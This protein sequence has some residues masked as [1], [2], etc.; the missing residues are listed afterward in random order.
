MP[1]G[2]SSTRT[3]MPPWLRLHVGDARDIAEMLPRTKCLDATI[4]SPPYG[5]TIDYGHAAQIGFGQAYDA[6]LADM[7]R[8]LGVLWGRTRDTGSLWLIVDSFKERARSGMSRL[9]PLPF[10]LAGLAEKA[11]WVLQ[12]VII[13]Q[14]DHTLPW[15]GQ[16]RLRNSFEYILMLAKGA[17]FKYRLDRIRESSG[18]QDWWH[19][20]PER[21][22]PSGAAPTNVW[23]FPIPRQGS[24]GNGVIEHRCPLPDGL[25]QR[26]VELSTDPGDVVCDPFAGIGTV[27]AVAE[28][29]DRRSIG[30]E[31][32]KDHAEQFYAVVLPE[33]MARIQVSTQSGSR[34]R[35]ARQ[36]AHLRHA[37]LA[38]TLV[39]RLAS[40]GTPVAA[41]VAQA[42]VKLPSREHPYSVGA[43]HIKLYLSGDADV[44]QA[45][46]RA[47]ELLRRRPLSKFGIEASVDVRRLDEW[48]SPDAGGWSRVSLVGTR[49][50]RF[51]N[52]VAPTTA[53]P[54]VLIDIDAE[55]LSRA[56]TPPDRKSASAELPNEEPMNS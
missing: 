26:I 53:E 54:L 7:E 33:T 48:V 29:L 35:F 34:L 25:V 9:V 28:A 3:S 17:E 52:H 37:K 11:G 38:R 20:Y 36:I 44:E 45:S 39:K 5:P 24:W 32:V 10:D 19:R 42:T 49:F 14:K 51:D 50:S 47:Q 4:T 6:Y 18:L 46:Q 1:T 40:L 41:A 31:L 43:Q 13:W 30:V 55:A 2:R 16:G 56:L 12:D 15:S 22:S 27:L 23:Q 21:Y 8:L